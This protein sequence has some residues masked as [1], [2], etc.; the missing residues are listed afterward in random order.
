[1]PSLATRYGRNCRNCTLLPQTINV[2][3]NQGDLFET[4]AARSLLDQLLEDSRLY[5]QSADYKALLDFVIRLRNFAPF[6]AMLLQVQKPGLSYAASARDW[7]ERFGRTVQEAARP[8]LILW[9]F[10]PVALVYDVMDTEGKP[11]PEDVASFVAQGNID[12][13]QIAGFVRLMRKKGLEWCLVDAGDQKAGSIRVVR[14][15]AANSK[16]TTLYRMHINRNHGPNVQFTTLAHE[17]GHLFLGHF[18]PDRA[19]NVPERPRLDHAQQELEAESVAYLVCA[20]NGVASKSETYLKDYVTK[21]TTVESLDL[22]QV[23][24]AA[25]QAETLLGLTERRRGEAVHQYI[26][27]GMPISDA[28]EQANLEWTL[29]EPEDE[30]QDQEA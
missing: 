15:A 24:R 13:H 9:P 23:M 25:G 3:I 30:E 29:W 4:E 7:R 18:G 26:Q 6:N 16:E 21:N 27:A 5:T 10:G 1:M 28:R 2:V 12:E 8:L 19:L 11:L 14:R 17:L 20:R 22:Y